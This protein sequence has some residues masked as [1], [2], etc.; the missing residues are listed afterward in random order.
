MQ[1]DQLY[2]N[3]LYRQALRKQ[4]NSYTEFETNILIGIYVMNAQAMRCSGNTLFNYLATIHRT[5]YK[6]NLLA[7]LRK[8][9]KEDRIRGNN[10]GA[11]TNI[12]L[13]EFGKQYLF[14]LEER[15]RSFQ[16]NIEN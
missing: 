2:R 12:R 13:T 1:A 7:T 5:P 9:K 6:K 3:L 11:G 10:A 15:L 8:F 4:F 14:D 16:F